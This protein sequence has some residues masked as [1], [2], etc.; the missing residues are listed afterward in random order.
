MKTEGLLGG[1]RRHSRH[2]EK[3]F[4]T[5]RRLEENSLE[6]KKQVPCHKMWK[7]MAF[8]GVSTAWL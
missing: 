2:C 7:Q 5:E 8:W 4:E 3:A 1:N 6:R